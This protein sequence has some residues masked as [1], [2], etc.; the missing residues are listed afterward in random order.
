MYILNIIL[1]TFMFFLF[2]WVIAIISIIGNFIIDAGIYHI[3]IEKFSSRF[4]YKWK[5]IWRAYGLGFLADF[6]GAA[7]LVF[8]Y[9]VTHNHI[10]Y[11]QIYDSWYNILVHLIIV[12]LSGYLVYVFNRL[13]LKN[14]GL[15]LKDQFRLSLSMAIITAPYTFLLPAALFGY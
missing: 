5:Y 2:S 11:F 4:I 10:N 14:S 1:P 13:N 3:Y 7:I 9:S 8:L 6:I 15:E 12:G